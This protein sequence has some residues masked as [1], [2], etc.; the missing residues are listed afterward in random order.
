MFDTW[1]PIA[2]RPRHAARMRFRDLP[3]AP[4][5]LAQANDLYASGQLLKALRY[6]ATSITVVAK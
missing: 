1:T 5:T 2:V 3:N 4:V 6:T